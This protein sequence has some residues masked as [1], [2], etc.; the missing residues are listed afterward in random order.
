VEIVGVVG[1]Y[2][3]FVGEALGKRPLGR[4]DS[5]V[6]DK[7]RWIVEITLWICWCEVDDVIQDRVQGRAPI[8]AVLSFRFLVPQY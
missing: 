6:R 5:R 2:A 3:D 8:L 1:I 4:A 7:V